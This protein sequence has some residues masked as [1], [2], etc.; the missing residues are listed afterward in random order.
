VTTIATLADALDVRA[1]RLLALAE[2]R[3]DLRAFPRKAG[4]SATRDCSLRE[5]EAVSTCAPRRRPE[6][7]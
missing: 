2:R 4:G 5:E 7:A 3:Q 1:S 6:R